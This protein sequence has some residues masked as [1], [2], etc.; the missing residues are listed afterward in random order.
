[1]R[2]LQTPLPNNR[3]GAAAA[4]NAAM[5]SVRTPASEWWYQIQTNTFQTMD[6]SRWQRQYLTLPALQYHVGM[7]L[8]NCRTCIDGGNRIS[9]YFSSNPPSLDNYLSGFF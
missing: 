2:N 3:G 7:L 8:V 9:K 1:M 4:L 6:F 5:A